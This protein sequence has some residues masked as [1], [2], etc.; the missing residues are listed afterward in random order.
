MQYAHG[1]PLARTPPPTLRNRARP[2]RPTTGFHY[3][4]VASAPDRPLMRSMRFWRGTFAF[5][6]V[7]CMLCTFKIID[8]IFSS[9]RAARV[10]SPASHRVHAALSADRAAAR[11]V[12][13]CTPLAAR[14]QRDKPTSMAREL[15]RRA[16]RPPVARFQAGFQTPPRSS[17]ARALGPCWSIRRA[18]FGT[19]AVRTADRTAARSA[20]SAAWAR[21]LA[22]G[23]TRAGLAYHAARGIT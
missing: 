14:R 17:A 23:E 6:F 21:W 20:L 22:G 7:L 19:L 4:Q 2:C 18:V 15:A 9:V 5:I 13:P 11:Q 3:H 16:G 1:T 10:S 12:R 8:P